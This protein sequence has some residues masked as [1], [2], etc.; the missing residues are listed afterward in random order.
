M[1][2][3]KVA[4][5]DLLV[6]HEVLVGTYEEYVLGYA[7]SPASSDFKTTFTDHAHSGSLK[8]VAAAGKFLITSG[9]DENVKIFNLRNRTEHGGLHHS[10][11]A[12]NILAF[13]DERHVVTAGEDNKYVLLN[14]P[15]RDL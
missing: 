8:A 10:D 5:M 15:S 11:A 7:P 13:Y 9:A 12:V 1:R 2:L 4:V 6:G 14:A 3:P